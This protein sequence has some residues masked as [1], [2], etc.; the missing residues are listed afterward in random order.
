MRK[1]LK[2]DR[3]SMKVMSLNVWC[4]NIYEPLVAFL[5]EHRGTVDVFCFQEV[6]DTTDPELP[7]RMGSSIDDV[8]DLFEQMKVLL[9]KYTACFT[10]RFGSYGQAIFVRNTVQVLSSSS[11]V[12]KDGFGR[13]LSEGEQ[14]SIAMYV[15]VMS[16]GSPY[17][18]INV[19]G[20]WVPN[21]GKDDSPARIEQSAAI[22]DIVT[23]SQSPVILCGDFNLNLDT[24]SVRILEQAGLRNLIREHGITS[25]RSSLY[26]KSPK[27]ADYIF[28]S[29][30][31]DVQSF[32]V[33][34][35]EVSDHLPLVIDVS[36]KSA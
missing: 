5:T 23:A 7:K 6:H 29:P 19:H 16:D 33:L 12:I 13:I 4:G 24:K 25:T 11:K 17:R 31:L 1:K 35:D 27:F 28:T 34:Q 21:I 14:P 32:E 15:D 18:I 3:T 26:L 10:P 8:H 30:E 9:P 22:V 36:K 2:I 20:L